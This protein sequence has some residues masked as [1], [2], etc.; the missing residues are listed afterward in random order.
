MKTLT[1]IL[2]FVAI[3]GLIEATWH[4]VRIRGFSTAERSKFL[5][6]A[7]S[8]MRQSGRLYD[9]MEFLQYKMENNYGGE[10]SCFYMN[11]DFAGSWRT[12]KSIRIDEGNKSILCFQQ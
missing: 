11:G 4:V 1:F 3:L 10:W 5:R 6:D 2:Y 7:R 12:N 9:K 8:A